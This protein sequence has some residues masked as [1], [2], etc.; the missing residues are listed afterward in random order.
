MC[1]ITG[2]W[3]K[4]QPTGLDLE[5]SLSVMTQALRHRGP[6]DIGTWV[7]P[8]SSLGLGHTRLSVMDLSP[9]GHQP[10]VS[11]SGRHV[12]VFNGEIYN[13]RAL[14]S[15]LREAGTLLVGHSD[16]EVLVECI[17][18]WGVASTLSRLNGM[19][20]VAIWNRED[21]SLVLAR[22]SQ[23]IKPL[24]YGWQGD[25][26]L[27]GSELKAL[28]RFPAFRRRMNLD[29][30]R[31][32]FSVNY[33]PAP[34]T[35]WEGIQKLPAG[36]Y[37]RFTGPEEKKSP[38]PFQSLKTDTEWGL[39]N[40][41]ALLEH[42]HTLLLSAVREQMV[43]DVPIGA[44]LS[45]GIDSSL[46]TALMQVQSP[47]RIRTFAI[48]FQDKRLDE[49]PYAQKVANHLGTDHTE[50]ILST[51]EAGEMV[52][53]LARIYDEPFADSSQI[54]TC[55]LSHLTRSQVTVALSGDGGDELFAGYS[56]YGTVLN[57]WKTIN[58]FPRWFL[59]ALNRSCKAMEGKNLLLRERQVPSWAAY[60]ENKAP[61][62]SSLLESVLQKDPLGF[63]QRSIQNHV[64]PTYLGP[65]ATPKVARLFQGSDSGGS[66]DAVAM[67]SRCD[68]WNYLPEDILTKVDR[69]SMAVALEVRVPLLD[70][71][72]VHLASQIPTSI[73]MADGR[74][75]WPLRQILKRY[76]PEDCIDRP[77]MGFRVP[78][79]DWLRGPL[80]EW[81]SHLLRNASVTE[82]GILRADRVLPLWKH[83][84]A[85]ST[86]S[87]KA[88]W[89][90]LMFQAWREE[91]SPAV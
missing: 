2:L 61:Q 21:R 91:W 66:G 46:V 32:Y 27:F 74:G 58:L 31:K 22:D 1:G 77:K 41:E 82:D 40:V 55:L 75:K 85:G 33:I 73:K 64:I 15:E 44:F 49:S 16:T 3:F 42:L 37:I 4:K 38:K 72:L 12:I 10:M 57:R 45:G 80:K 70:G 25:N 26:L 50:W 89:P 24:Y 68:L 36:H 20:A 81:G 18:R 39:D 86:D 62:V 29:S 51:R 19:F 8:N 54:P 76:L 60:W 6:D 59:K 65:R 87:S 90:I 9:M 79:G 5:S 88:L 11:K 13:F 52:P 28:V 34:H 48:G 63:Y 78:L 14:A 7:E 83:H 53:R 23:G 43:T 69:A 71:R 17:D 67:M 84:L 47:S 30:L 35:I 56:H